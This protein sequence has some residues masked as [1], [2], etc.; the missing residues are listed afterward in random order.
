MDFLGSGNASPVLPVDK[1]GVDQGGWTSWNPTLTGITLGNGTLSCAYK[2]VTK[3]TV[4][5]RCQ[6]TV[7]STT[8]HTG[9]I[10]F[11]LPFTANGNQI[12]S[13]PIGQLTILDASA[14]TR[15]AGMALLTS[16]TT[17]EL[18]LGYVISGYVYMGAIS[19]GFPMTLATGDKLLS[20]GTYE[21]A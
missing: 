3:K 20:S 5:Y 9:A 6:L 1:G 4:A 15:I 17:C 13:L 12:V 11:T 18:S 8:S 16:S 2:Q 7:G 10:S 21:V 14:S 19:G